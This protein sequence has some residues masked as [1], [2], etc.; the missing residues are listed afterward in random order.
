MAVQPM[1][2]T[3]ARQIYA[4][5]DSDNESQL[6]RVK[7]TQ[8]GVIDD[9]S[10]S[11]GEEIALN[12][13]II[14]ILGTPC[15]VDTQG[16][17][18]CIVFPRGSASGGTIPEKEIVEDPL[19]QAR[20]IF[21]RPMNSESQQTLEYGFEAL[22][23]GPVTMQVYQDT[24]RHKFMELCQRTSMKVDSFESIDGDEVFI[25]IGFDRD[26]IVIRELAQ[27]YVYHMPVGHEIYTQYAPE[28][29]DCPGGEMLRNDDGYLVPAYMPYTMEN[30]NEVPMF[31]S[32]RQ[33]DEIRL[34]LRRFS[35]WV[36]LEEMISQN[37]IV[38]YFPIH[39]A[40]RLQQL[41]EDFGSPYKMLVLPNFPRE[42]RVRNYFGEDVAFFFLWCTHYLHGL[43]FL[44]A[45]GALACALSCLPMINHR[46]VRIIQK[47][48]TMVLMLWTALTTRIWKKTSARYKQV[49]GM[50]HFE[51][52]DVELTSYD[53]KLERTWSLTC[54]H[55]FGTFMVVFYLLFYMVVI[56]AAEWIKASSREEGESSTAQSSSSRDVLVL[57]V[58]VNLL[59]FAWAKIAPKL[60]NL[61]NHRTRSSYNDALSYSLATVK[62]FIAVYPFLKA[63][64]L[65]K[66][67]NITCFEALPAALN[68]MYPG[69]GS[70]LTQEAVD[71][72][73][74]KHF[75]FN[76]TTAAG[77]HRVCSMGCFP[78][79]PDFYTHEAIDVTN[80][81]VSLRQTLGQFYAIQAALSIVFLLIPIILTK[82]Q[83]K[84]EEAKAGSEKQYT[85][86][87]LQ[88]KCSELAPYEFA[89]WGGS[90]MEDFLDQV[91]GFALLTCFSSITPLVSIIAFI[92]NLIV[93]RLLAYRMTRVTARPIPHGAPGIGFWEVALEMISR[94]AIITTVA[95]SAFNVWP[96][97]DLTL[98]HRLVSFITLEH[99]IFVLSFGAY[100]LI[101]EPADVQFI[102]KYNSLVVEQL[103]VYDVLPMEGRHD[104]QKVDVSVNRRGV[105]VSQGP[106][107]WHGLW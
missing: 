39:E 42:S 10:D 53:P 22:K 89:S 100:F 48:Y 94:F 87:Q 59:S 107:E 50:Q 43:V 63:A 13:E 67:T 35:R 44:A 105:S 30:D 99:L 65:K 103:K 38:T 6:S 7:L 84:Q 37:V 70:N 88:A 72:L 74:S 80:C 2:G 62:V 77:R 76:R 98:S 3:S 41:K 56:S 61:Q 36:D 18:V 19:E 69:I 28:W 11:E 60:V 34:I 8:G 51:S 78:A 75:L 12:G 29:G 33:V 82:R 85:L 79:E 21:S 24:I 4:T 66:Y 20:L 40:R 57:T 83:V 25:K 64:F 55:Q 90:P 14:E 46:D 47:V 31:Q 23:R 54:R 81:S 49:W 26:G 68:H 95:T 91:I 45:V 1:E 102:E 15:V 5:S 96:F 16:Y 93:Y 32:F 71:I 9:D 86:L 27:R 52:L 17:S 73:W 106:E 104:Y 92:T 97:S 58:I 101:P